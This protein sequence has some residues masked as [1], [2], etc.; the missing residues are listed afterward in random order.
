MRIQW[1]DNFDAATEVDADKSPVILTIGSFDGVHRGHQVLIR[2]VVQRAKSLGIESL[3]LTFDPL[4]AEVLSHQQGLELSDI[5]ERLRLFD[6]VMVDRAAVLRFTTEASLMP[7]DLF[8]ASLGERYR[9]QEIWSGA[10]FA[11]GHERE[12]N[13]VFLARSTDKYGFGLHVI[14]REVCEGERL[15]SSHI[16]DLVRAGDVATATQLLGHYP[17]ISG[18]VKPGAGRGRDLGYPTANLEVS[19]QRLLPATGIYAGYAVRTGAD[20]AR[21][22]SGSFDDEPY[23]DRTRLPAVISI[24]HNPTFGVNP[25]SVEA[26]ILDFDQDVAR[27]RLTLELV[28]RMRD[29]ALFDSVEAL[30]RQM[31][32][33]VRQTRAILSEHREATRPSGTAEGQPA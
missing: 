32:E 28:E 19:H 5:E 17:M 30:V 6:G 22:S 21:L 7:A 4:P 2:Q 26:F 31:E 20:A 16:R 12:G 25:L 18:V 10:D 24:G 3:V 13:V 15:A 1:L 11:F 29:E 9:I 14:S 33:D 23:S 27:E 8:L